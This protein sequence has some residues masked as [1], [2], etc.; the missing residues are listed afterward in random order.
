LKLKDMT[1]LHYN[2]LTKHYWLA[3][4]VDVNYMVYTINE[5]AQ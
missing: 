1:G 3:P 2:P 5:S 4:N